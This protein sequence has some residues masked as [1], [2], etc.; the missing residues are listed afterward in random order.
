MLRLP[1]F[2]FTMPRT[3]TEAATILAADPQHTRLVAGGTDLYPNLKRRHQSA[4]TVVSLRR[5]AS[6]RGIRRLADGGF[7][8]GA[9]TTLTEITQSAELQS[10]Y[11]GFVR[12]VATISAPVLRNMGTIGG[13]LCLDTRCTYYNQS[14]EWRRSIDYCLKEV[15]STCWVAPGSPRCWAISASDSAPVLCAIGAK[16]RLVSTAGERMIDLVDLFRDDGINYLTKRRDE[17]LTDVVLPAPEGQKTNYWKLRR[18]GSIDFPVLGVGV[19]LSTD[20]AGAVTRAKI[21][22][23]AVASSPIEATV[24]ESLLVG[25]ILTE[26]PIAAAAA[27]ALKVATPMDNTDF[28]VNWRKTMVERYVDGALRETIGVQPKGMA[29]QAGLWVA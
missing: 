29:P 18:R 6:L 1:S 3:I 2:K 23:G 28:L 5:L 16:V 24:S 4:E 25:Q 26:S 14:E 8:I 10:A 27:Q 21:F 13:N 17:I 9:M 7:S 20:A 15:G 12:A 11:P 22:L 19:S